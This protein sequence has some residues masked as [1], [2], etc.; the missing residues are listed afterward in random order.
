MNQVSL[1]KLG[2]HILYTNDYQEILTWYPVI[3]SMAMDNSNKSKSDVKKHLILDFPFFIKYISYKWK[4]SHSLLSICGL[5][6][7]IVKVLQKI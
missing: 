4:L 7:D 6:L 3:V 2:E 1:M 5:L